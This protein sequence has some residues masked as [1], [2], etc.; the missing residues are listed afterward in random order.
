MQP[1]SI[2]AIYF[3]F[4]VLTA[5]AM[6]PFGYES[7]PRDDPEYVPGQAESAPRHFRPGRVAL[8]TTL[9]ASAFFALFYLNYVNGWI[10]IE[11]V[12]IS[13]LVERPSS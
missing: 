11:D 1:T 5:L 12:D 4:W 2:V 3:L 7:V 9:V 8:R 10:T 13:R 6:L